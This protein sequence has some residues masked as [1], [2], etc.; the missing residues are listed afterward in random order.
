ME[1]VFEYND[2]N[3]DSIIVEALTSKEFEVLKREYTDIMNSY[4]LLSIKERNMKD[5]DIVDLIG[6]FEGKAL[7]EQYFEKSKFYPDKLLCKVLRQLTIRVL[8]GTAIYSPS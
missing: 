4:P 6:D 7:G 5:R 1:Q 8:E 3:I 2:Q